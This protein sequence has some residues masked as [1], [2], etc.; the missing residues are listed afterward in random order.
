MEGRFVTS[1]H[2]CGAIGNV[3]S[4]QPKGDKYLIPHSMTDW[5]GSHRK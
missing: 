2:L 1:R 3:V 5:R 4:S